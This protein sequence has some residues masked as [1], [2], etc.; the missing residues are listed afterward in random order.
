MSA[1]L[2]L[3]SA[4]VAAAGLVTAVKRHLEQEH[5][6]DVFTGATGAQFEEEVETREIGVCFVDSRYATRASD[7]N[8][9]ECVR[10]WQLMDKSPNIHRICI[11]LEDP[12]D[13]IAAIKTARK[14]GPLCGDKAISEFAAAL[15]LPG[16][17]VIMCT[18]DS[19]EIIADKIVA[20]ISS[21]TSAKTKANGR[22]HLPYVPVEVE[23]RRPSLFDGCSPTSSTFLFGCG[24]TMIEESPPSSDYGTFISLP[25]CAL[26]YIFS[27]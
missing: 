22:A 6:C 3:F 4:D 15:R 19:S 23:R 21:D 8:R 12:R 24:P 1:A 26:S 2:V 25:R 27:C 13:V 20:H 10:E 17:E 11:M 7:S 18:G 16:D 14:H 5:S 9:A